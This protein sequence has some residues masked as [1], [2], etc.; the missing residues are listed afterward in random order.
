MELPFRFLFADWALAIEG[1][2]SRR[3]AWRARAS[4]I[5]LALS[6]AMT[7]VL[8]AAIAL[9]LRSALRATRLSQMKTEFVSNVSH[10]LRT[11][12]ASIRVLRRVP[13]PRAA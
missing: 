2:A 5:N 9:A 4:C 3:R 6:L 11:P 7:A 1:P 12:L 8:L 10:E 13:A